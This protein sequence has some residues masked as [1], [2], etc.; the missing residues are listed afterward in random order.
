MRN[1]L[2][3]LAIVVGLMTTANGQLLAQNDAPQRLAYHID[4]FTSG[5]RDAIATDLSRSGEF[6]I[7]YAC[8]PA[9]ILVIARADDAIIGHDRSRVEAAL[10]PWI[11]ERAVARD[12]RD[13]AELE[14]ACLNVRNQ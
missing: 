10:D 1:P 13:Q 8:V 3:I 9:G 11:G 4:G 5:E 7:A 14:A 2:Y 12:P 6:R